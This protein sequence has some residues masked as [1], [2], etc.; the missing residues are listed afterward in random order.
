MRDDDAWGTSSTVTATANRPTKPRVCLPGSTIPLTKAMGDRVERRIR[1]GIEDL[2]PRGW[3]LSAIS[4]LGDCKASYLVT[5]SGGAYHCTCYDSIYGD[6]RAAK[7]DGCS[8]VLAVRVWRERNEVGVEPTQPSET[9]TPAQTS[10]Q[11]TPRPKGLAVGIGMPNSTPEPNPT[12]KLPDPDTI[13]TPDQWATLHP[14]ILPSTVPDWF[15]RVAEQPGWPAK[16]TALR[17]WQVD[18]IE[19]GVRA[20]RRG[21][22]AVLIEAP[23][24]A[25]KTGIGE[26]IRRLIGERGNYVCTTKTLQDQFA[27][28]FASGVVL[29]GRA[30][31]DPNI[32]EWARTHAPHRIEHGGDLVGV[33]AAD[34][35]HTN[36]KACMLCDEAQFEVGEDP[37]A[38]LWETGG[39]HG[40]G[41]GQGV[42]EA[43]GGGGLDSSPF[44]VLGSCCYVQAKK[45]AERADLNIVNTAYFIRVANSRSPRDGVSIDADGNMVTTQGI[46]GRKVV[47]C[48][49]A[50]TLE[51]QI[52]GWAEVQ[53]GADLVARHKIPKPDRVTVSE[54]WPSWIEEFVIPAL[55]KDVESAKGDL[56][57]ST[58][59]GGVKIRRRIA[60]IVNKLESLELVCES[61]RLGG[62]WILD[63]YQDHRPTYTF[64]PVD[65]SEFGDMALWDHGEFFVLMSATFIDA[66]AYAKSIGLA[67][68]D[69][70]VIKVPSSFPIQ[71]RPVVNMAIAANTYKN[72]DHAQPLIA[73]NIVSL[74]RKHAGERVLV[75]SVSYEFTRFVVEELE[76]AGLD[77]PIITYDHGTKRQAALELYTQTPGAVAVAPSWD[78][79]VDL[80][81]DLCRVQIIAKVPFPSLGDK[82]VSAKMHGPGGAAWYVQE[83]IRTL[84]QMVGRG[85]RSS[86]DWCWTYILDESFMRILR[87]NNRFLPEFFR[88]A[89]TGPGFVGWCQRDVDARMKTARY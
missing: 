77:H 1:N 78:R 14:P 26:G 24:G 64:K 76:A 44:A 74:A 46:A 38:G 11:D 79:G 83:T 55:M 80:P 18:A 6:S 10:T 7:R 20:Y 17:P 25:G 27:E 61:I 87:E 72:K 3:G 37:F 49:E 5:E 81:G 32:I 35:N 50:D 15:G 84:V 69:I 48:D 12:P 13:L 71:H 73:K 54:H 43:G 21:K 42:L 60:G 88:L 4:S 2:S 52:M 22:K 66:V 23:T 85:C 75:H 34:C 59:M 82:L 41:G 51:Q 36:S 47:I 19:A 62:V 53:V 86:D 58:G 16:I 45:A 29:K 57:K 30:N 8:H 67:A 28:D 33:T 68:R 31:Y 56:E 40:F 9:I 70:E 89:L 63:D 39:G 65:V